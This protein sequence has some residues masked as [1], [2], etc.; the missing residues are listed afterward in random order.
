MLNA[1][2]TLLVVAVLMG[3]LL[4]VPYL[5]EG[6]APPWLLGVLHGLIAMSGLA[7]LALALRGSPRGVAQGVGSFGAIA[8]ALIAVAALAGLVQFILRLR[9]Q[10]PP[11]ALIGVHATLAIGGFIILLVYVLG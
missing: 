9:R 4:A 7:L 6:A 1:A 11:G 10:R 2:F 8:A 5:R 3:S